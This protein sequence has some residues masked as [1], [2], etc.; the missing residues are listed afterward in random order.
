MGKIEVTTLKIINNFIQNQRNCDISLDD[1]DNELF[2]KYINKQKLFPIIYPYIKN[3]LVIDK[4]LYDQQY[5]EY[6]NQVEMYEKE[7]NRVFKYFNENGLSGVVIKGI[8]LSKIIYGNYYSR[9]FGDIDL[10]FDEYNME[11]ADKLL[12][13]LGY[14]QY[15]D[16]IYNQLLDKPLLKLSYLHEYFPYRKGVSEAKI[17]NVFIE[18]SKNLHSRLCNKKYISQMIENRVKVN[19]YYTLCLEDTFIELIENTYEDVFSDYAMS[20]GTANL[21]NYLDLLMFMKKFKFSTDKILNIS[22]KYEFDFYLFEVIKGITDLFPKIKWAQQVKEQMIMNRIEINDI[23]SIFADKKNTVMALFDNKISRNE[24]NIAIKNDYYSLK[25]ESL[26]I[27]NTDVIYYKAKLGLLNSDIEY[28][29]SIKDGSAYIKLNLKT[30]I[31]DFL[32]SGILQIRVCN[33]N[34]GSDYCFWVLN[35]FIVD[36]QWYYYVYNCKYLYV[37]VDIKNGMLMQNKKLITNLQVEKDKVF[38]NFDFDLAKNDFNLFSKM[39]AGGCSLLK[40]MEENIY[41]EID[42]NTNNGNCMPVFVSL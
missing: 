24:N 13:D 19:E 17:N 34:L 38:L 41:F 42:N 12:R 9:R 11:K 26:L 5:N 40:K 21:R 39:L 28:K 2:L 27:P 1:I 6:L 18:V 32:H 22:Q 16:F 4:T 36:G 23:D 15:N 8:A 14:I 35:V 3:N 7:L 10:L 31:C 33:N 20:V 37:D 29:L 30:D 25:N